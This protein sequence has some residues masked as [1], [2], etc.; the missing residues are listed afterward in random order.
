MTRWPAII[1]CCFFLAGCVTN[2]RT[3]YQRLGGEAGVDAIVYQ[4]LVNIAEDKRVD[5][6]FRA[7]DI[8]KFRQGFVMYIC[9]IADGGCEYDNDSMRA[10]HA[11]HNY[12]DTEFNAIVD[13]LIRAMD[14]EN[15]DTRTQNALL[16]LLAP[17]YKDVVYL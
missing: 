7:V 11:G 8:E 6:R 1:V 5:H 14:A 15:I 3:L 2:E 4:L 9:S 12:T 13:N 17:T 16:A 10:I